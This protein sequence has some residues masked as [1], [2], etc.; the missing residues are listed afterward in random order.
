MGPE[1]IPNPVQ[2]EDLVVVVFRAR[3]S[4]VEHL[5]F[6]Q[7]VGGSIPPALTEFAEHPLFER[8]SPKTR[9]IYRDCA[10]RLDASVG[11]LPITEITPEHAEKYLS[12]RNTHVSPVSLKVDLRCL[13][14]FFNHAIRLG[15]IEKNPIQYIRVRV[16]QKQPA[17]L[18]Q[19]DFARLLAVIDKE[20]LRRIVVFAA[21][22]GMRRQEI[23]K[24]RWADVDMNA[25]TVKIESHREF[26]AMCGASRIIPLSNVAYEV[27]RTVYAEHKGGPPPSCRMA[28]NIVNSQVRSVTCRRYSSCAVRE[29]NWCLSHS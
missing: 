11:H 22:T 9:R 25:R 29:H 21:C 19:S 8:Y 2:G 14:A 17:Y 20:W 27:L 5:P 28:G 1:W 15:Y 10:K 23:V 13:K 26:H 6:K 7:R 12:E 18:T 16:E 4:E 3:S 24:L